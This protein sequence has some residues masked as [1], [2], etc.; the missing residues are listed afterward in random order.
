MEGSVIIIDRNI[1]RE[2]IM[3]L[4]LRQFVELCI[5]LMLMLLKYR[6]ISVLSFYR[7]KYDITIM[8][9]NSVVIHQY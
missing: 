5:N 2:Y 7:Y 4:I 1:S 3:L 6:N 9:I 8:L